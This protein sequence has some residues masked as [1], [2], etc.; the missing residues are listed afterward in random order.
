MSESSKVAPFGWMNWRGF[1]SASIWEHIYLGNTKK[2]KE[3][4]PNVLL[5][6]ELNKH[7][8][9]CCR[10]SFK[11]IWCVTALGL[12]IAFGQKEI[13]EILLNQSGIDFTSNDS[14]GYRVFIYFLNWV[15]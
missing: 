8:G 6:K 7:S 15:Y 11:D 4:L 9:N 10:D 14:G 3:M 1:P 13:F 5:R 2:V 12:S